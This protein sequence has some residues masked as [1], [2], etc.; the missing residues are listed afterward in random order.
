MWLLVPSVEVRRQLLEVK[1]SPSTMILE[2]EVRPPALHVECFHP[3]SHW[4]LLCFCIITLVHFSAIFLRPVS[5]YNPQWPGAHDPP[6]NPAPPPHWAHAVSTAAHCSLTLPTL[7]HLYICASFNSWE[8]R[9]SAYLLITIKPA[10]GAAERS[11]FKKGLWNNNKLPVVITGWSL[12]NQP[13]ESLTPLPHWE[14]RSLPHLGS[15][16]YVGAMK[17]AMCSRVPLAD[18]AQDGM[19]LYKSKPGWVASCNRPACLLIKLPQ[20]PSSYFS[21][22]SKSKA[23]EQKRAQL[24]TDL[25]TLSLILEQDFTN[26]RPHSLVCSLSEIWSCS[27]ATALRERNGCFFMEQIKRA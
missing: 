5:L 12:F 17:T 21:P 3:L 22:F 8:K 23:P 16:A 4:G 2:A 11:A 14:C 15:L 20:I 6:A 25:R 7:T 18:Q 1:F 26:S 24:P 13:R 27:K 19:S 10:Y 9:K